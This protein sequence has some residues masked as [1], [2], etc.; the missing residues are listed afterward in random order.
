MTKKPE[1]IIVKNRQIVM[2]QIHWAL[3]HESARCS[4]LFILHFNAS[5]FSNNATFWNDTEPTTSVIS[6]GTNNRVNGSSESLVCYAW[7]QV[8]G[9]PVSFETYIGNGNANGPFVYT[10]FRPRL[11]YFKKN[12]NSAY[13]H[14]FDTARNVNNT[15][16]TYLLWDSA[17][18]DDTASSNSIDFLSNGFK[19]RNNASQD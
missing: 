15:V 12:A 7:A 8:E 13:W 14:I 6:L 17:A 5:I 18:A 19:L 10:G 2:E 16:D 1:F 4:R 9:Y 3:Y 11:V